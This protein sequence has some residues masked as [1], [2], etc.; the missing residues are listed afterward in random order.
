MIIVGDIGNTE[1]K[2]CFFYNGL[3]KKYLFKTDSLNKK[4]IR[5]KFKFLHKKSHT[6]CGFF[7]QI[8]SLEFESCS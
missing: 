5:K 4:I 3:K 8:T 2:I 6:K 1:V 7:Y